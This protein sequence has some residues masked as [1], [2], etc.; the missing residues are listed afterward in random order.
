MRPKQSALRVFAVAALAAS[1]AAC[2]SHHSSSTAKSR[3][4]AQVPSGNVIKI[5]IDLP[6]SGADASIGVTTRNGAVMAIEEANKKGVPSGFQIKADDLDDAV[7]GVHS[8]QQGAS[9]VRTF[10]SDPSV[11][12]MIGPFNSNVAKSQIPL[13]NE[14]G[15]AQVSPSNT[16]DGLTKGADAATLRRNRPDLNTYFRVCTIDS[17]QGQAAAQFARRLHF[18][19]AYVI[20]DN[21]TYGLGLANVFENSFKQAGGTILGHDHITKN[22]QDFKALLTKIGASHPDVIFFGGTTSNGGGLIRKQMFDAGMNNVAYMG[23]DGISDPEFLKVAGTSANGSY[24]TV[25]APNAAALPSARS[26]VEAYRKRWGSDVGPYS[27]S[28][29]TAAN[30]LVA[31]IDEAIRANGNKMPTREQVLKNVAATKNMESPIG[32]VGF[33]KDGDSTNPILSLYAVKNG[34]A[35]FNGQLNLMI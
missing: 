15:L 6:V 11:L 10:I 7:N 12:A 14:A 17:R 23:G 2:S 20:D 25:A 27:A 29:Y 28:A 26:F 4:S 33:D 24:Y 21:E 8:P 32:K 34:K 9:N 3:S 30:V 18:N 1:L 13:T 22:Q 31:A 16:N 5:G 35:V 19:K